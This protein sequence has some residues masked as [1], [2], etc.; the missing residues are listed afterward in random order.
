M[1]PTENPDRLALP[2]SVDTMILGKILYSLE[3]AVWKGPIVYAYDG[4]SLEIWGVD[5]EEWMFASGT[6]YLLPAVEDGVHTVYLR[7]EDYDRLTTDPD[8]LTKLRRG[9]VQACDK[10][11]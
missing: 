1:T 4:G 6:A 9:M 7:M 2:D 8:L 5:I 10:T 11:T 3:G